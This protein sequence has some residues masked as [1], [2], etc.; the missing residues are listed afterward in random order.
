LAFVVAVVTAA[1][2]NLTVLSAEANS[3]HLRWGAAASPA[4]LV[5]RVVAREEDAAAKEVVVHTS[6][7]E[8]LLQDLK[9]GTTYLVTV[10]ATLKGRVGKASEPIKATTFDD[11]Y[12][13]GKTPA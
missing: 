8:A 6:S 13:S 1:A 10:T 9:I 12:Q 7:K 3:L 5:Y 2:V 4:G 11:T